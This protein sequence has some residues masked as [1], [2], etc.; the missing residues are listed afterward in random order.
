MKATITILR[1]FLGL[2]GVTLVFQGFMWSFMPE[3]NL[4]MNEIVAESVLGIN[5]IKSDIGGALLAAG[6]F[7]VLFALK[8]GQWFYPTVIIAGS[9]FMVRTVSFIT[10]GYHQTILIGVILEGIVVAASI[11]LNQLLRKQNENVYSFNQ[12]V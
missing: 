12:N 8:G 7:L 6:T 1:I 4:E 9:Y 3:A 11:L 10:D 2:I 5:M